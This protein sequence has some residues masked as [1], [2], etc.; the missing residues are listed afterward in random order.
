MQD[1]TGAKMVY[2]ELEKES[3]ATEKMPFIRRGS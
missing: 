2:I 3:I 1:E